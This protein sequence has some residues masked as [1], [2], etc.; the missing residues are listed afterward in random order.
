[1][2]TYYHAGQLR[3]TD[4]FVHAGAGLYPIAEIREVWSAPSYPGANAVRRAVLLVAGAL[5]TLT[6]TFGLWWY[7]DGHW[8]RMGMA[9]PMEFL[10]SYSGF[11]LLT[12]GVVVL[13]R[14]LDP[15][16]GP[17]D[18]WVR[19]GHQPVRLAASL[20]GLELGKARRALRRACEH[21]YGD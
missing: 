15:A 7:L 21:Y 13:G 19:C 12:I 17:G 4:E 5:F 20:S 11:V 6:G 14:A 16:P 18:L 3:I 8:R 10:A 2:T 1:M 9:T